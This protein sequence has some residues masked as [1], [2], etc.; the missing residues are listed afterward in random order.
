[1][2][3]PA[4]CACASS[5]CVCQQCVRV[6]VCAF[7]RVCVCA[8]VRVCVCACVRVC[9]CACV[10]VCGPHLDKQGPIA[11]SLRRGVSRTR[12]WRREKE[13]SGAS[14]VWGATLP[15]RFPLTN[16]RSRQGRHTAATGSKHVRALYETSRECKPWHRRRNP[17]LPSPSPLR[18]RFTRSAPLQRRRR[19]AGKTWTDS[20]EGVE[21]GRKVFD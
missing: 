7:V 15:R 6:C 4:V 8:C 5:V 16:R 20:G 9:V 12:S 2:R 1:V 11:A 10:R 19:K 18:E 13:T 3:V 14:R 21:R 17:R